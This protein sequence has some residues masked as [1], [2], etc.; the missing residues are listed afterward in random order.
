M[1]LGLERGTGSPLRMD[2]TSGRRNMRR[3]PQHLAPR[4]SGGNRT[5]GSYLEGRE[6]AI[7]PPM[8]VL[9][10]E[11]ASLY[12]GGE[13]VPFVAGEGEDHFRRLGRAD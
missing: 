9:L 1:P 4:A 12:P 11:V 8:R 5:R 2:E 6:V 10:V 13:G 3:A 7:T